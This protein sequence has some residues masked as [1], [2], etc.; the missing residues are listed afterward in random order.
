M[1]ESDQLGRKD[2]DDKPKLGMVFRY[3]SKA[4]LEVAKCGTYG[5][6]K[7]GNGAFWDYNWNKLDKGYERYTDAM[8]RHLAAEPLEHTDKDTE[9]LHAT[10]VAWNALARLSFLVDERCGNE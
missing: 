7:Y 9:L 2:D 5:C 1:T 10:H 8:L 6:R 4:L 3:F